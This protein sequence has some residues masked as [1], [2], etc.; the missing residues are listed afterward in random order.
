MLPYFGFIR[1][2]YCFSN[3]LGNITLWMEG[4]L[5]YSGKVQPSHLNP[6]PFGCLSLPLHVDSNIELLTKPNDVSEKS[7]HSW[8]N[9]LHAQLDQYTCSF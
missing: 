3:I 8:C 9:F 6:P 5:T 2:P 7:T 4:E 1:M